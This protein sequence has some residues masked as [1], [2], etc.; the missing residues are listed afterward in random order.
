MTELDLELAKVFYSILVDICKGDAETITYGS[1]VEKAKKDFPNNVIV[2]NVIPRGIGRRLDTVRLLT[3]ELGYPDL[4]SLVVNAAEGEC[5]DGYPN[6]PEL[7]RQEVKEFNWEKVEQKFN[8]HLQ[9]ARASLKKN[10]GKK[11]ISKKAGMQKQSAKIM[12]DYYLQHKEN[13]PPEIRNYREQ[14]IEL[15]SDGYSAK[16]AFRKFSK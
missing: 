6:N 13:Y 15:I 12:A 1:L 3:N 2:Q 8:K 7:V 10:S 4:T 16:E 9:G 14:I 11:K 5:G